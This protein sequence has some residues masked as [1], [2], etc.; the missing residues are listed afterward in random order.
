MNFISML[1]MLLNLVICFVLPVVLIFRFYGKYKMKPDM[2]AAGFIVFL[3]FE[4]FLRMPFLR[5]FT[6]NEQ[7]AAYVENPVLYAL[8]LG[9]SAGLFD[10]VGRFIYYRVFVRDHM[11]WENGLAMGLGFASLEG[12]TVTG[13]VYVRRFMFSVM[14]HMGRYGELENNPSVTSFIEELKATPVYMHLLAGW[15]RITMLVIHTA[16]SL[17]TMY[18]AKRGRLSL[19]VLSFV[20]HGVTISAAVYF[21]NSA[22]WINGLYLPILAA[23]GFFFVI[24]K[25]RKKELFLFDKVKKEKAG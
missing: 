12:M 2:F 20:L 3:V 18:A 25:A 1:F 13:G 24:K 23:A 5:A 22:P 10:E 21:S 15:E 16:F 6:E 14:Y 4:L 9:F 17:L 11:T 19:L 8:L 7:Y